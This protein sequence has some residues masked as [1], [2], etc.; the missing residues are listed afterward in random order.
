MWLLLTYRLSRF[1]FWL[2]LR[3]SNT[4]FKW[5]LIFPKKTTERSP[6]LEFGENCLVKHNLE[7]GHVPH[8]SPSHGSPLM[9]TTWAWGSDG[10]TCFGA[11]NRGAECSK[12]VFHPCRVLAVKRKF[13]AVEIKW[14]Y[15]TQSW[16]HE[17]CIVFPRLQWK[18]IGFCQV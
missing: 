17:K 12:P 3:Y 8:L 15:S 2:A 13:Q 7:L 14:H 10:L 6:A 9:V 16:F 4:G 18:Y 1:I 5:K 11:A